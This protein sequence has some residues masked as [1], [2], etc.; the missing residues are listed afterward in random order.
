M[1][2]RFSQRWQSG[3]QRLMTSATEQTAL[4]ELV[5]L[6]AELAGTSAVG[7][8]KSRA[9]QLEAASTQPYP[10]DALHKTLL[11]EATQQLANGALEGALA[12]HARRGEVMLT[13]LPIGPAPDV[14]G[15]VALA[16]DAAIE[17]RLMVNINTVMVLCA[18]TLRKLRWQAEIE[19]LSELSAA[20]GTLREPAEV[21]QHIVSRISTIF[22]ISNSRIFLLD[23]RVG[24]LVMT[25]GPQT[26]APNADPVR[27]A[28]AGTIAGEVV[29]SEQALICSSDG[30]ASRTVSAY[31]TGFAGGHV[32]CVPLRFSGRVFGALM[33]ANPPEGPLFADEDLRLLTT[34]AGTVAALIANARL[35][36][37]A[38]RD[39]LTGAYNR[40]AFNTALEQNWARV[41]ACGGG[42]S[43]IL[44]DLDNF[45]HINDRFGHSIGDQ[46][47]QSVT[48]ILWE[49]LRTDDMIF[50]Y[51]GE[52]FCVLLS[53]VVDSPTALAIAERLRAALDCS[54]LINGLVRVPISASLGVAVHPLHSAQNPRDLLDIAD[55]AAYQAKRDGKNRVVL[56]SLPSH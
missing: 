39:A 16:G 1:S 54:L 35:Y 21:L 50:R 42:F 22:T 31:E 46:V 4:A 30:S 25:P 14:L 55:D 52:E 28:L 45:K 19:L 20:L 2:T 10:D 38:V 26:G 24:D 11:A 53:E 51:G 5:E 56:A 6:C 44:L 37:R 48:Q 18:Q 13:I 36:V 9:G 41:T 43:L 7:V 15:V 27:L 12:L 33:L 40:G 49:A 17:P 32:L 8:L 3:L 34:V 23:E 47:L 29:Q